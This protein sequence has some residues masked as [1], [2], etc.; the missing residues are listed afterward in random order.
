M[1]WDG[2]G[3]DF[4]RVGGESREP[5]RQR[6]SDWMTRRRFPLVYTNQAAKRGLDRTV[7]LV[8]FVHSSSIFFIFLTIGLLI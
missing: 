6:D 2:M 4:D 3:L 7:K 1:G 5:N 8:W